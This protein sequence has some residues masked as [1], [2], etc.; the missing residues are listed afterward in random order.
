MTLP[1]APYRAPR[2][3]WIGEALGALVIV[4]FWIVYGWGVLDGVRA[5]FGF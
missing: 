2:R 3:D 1:L 4:A 5:L